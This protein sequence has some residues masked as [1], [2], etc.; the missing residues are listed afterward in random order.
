LGPV[1][2]AYARKGNRKAFEGGDHDS[3]LEQSLLSDNSFQTQDAASHLHE[4]L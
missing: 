4:N 3:A 2:V 1:A